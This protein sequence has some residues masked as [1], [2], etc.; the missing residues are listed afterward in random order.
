MSWLCTRLVWGA[1]GG[2]L[3]FAWTDTDMPWSVTAILA[4]C[5]IAW[6]AAGVWWVKRGKE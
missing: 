4:V 5:S 3:W 6:L 2:L 1:C